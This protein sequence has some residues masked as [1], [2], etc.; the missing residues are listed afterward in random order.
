MQI[1]AAS[2]DPSPRGAPSPAPSL[3]P[4]NCPSGREPSGI[5]GFPYMAPDPGFLRL[6]FTKDTCRDADA[7]P[8][9]W[10]LSP[11]SRRKS[12]SFSTGERGSLSEGSSLPV[13]SP[14]FPAP[15][16]GAVRASLHPQHQLL[17]R[18]RGR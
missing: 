2:D 7:V 8:G 5:Q 6:K 9:S 18:S 11:W 1:H 16:V 12:V 14:S 15:I 4:P 10:A 13:P 17:A 3:P